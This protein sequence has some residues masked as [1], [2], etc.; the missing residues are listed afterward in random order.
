MTTPIKGDRLIFPIL[1]AYQVCL[2]YQLEQAGRPVCH[3]PIYWQG[4]HP[5]ADQC[6]CACPNGGQGQAWVRMVS[7]NAA[8]GSTR[9]AKCTNGLY[10]LTVE[11]GVYRCSPV[12]QGREPTVPAE[13]ETRHAAGMY[14]DAQALRHAM[15][16]CTWLTK[17]GVE[18]VLVH[19]SAIG[20]SGACVG[21]ELQ[22]RMQVIDCDCPEQQPS[23]SA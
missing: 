5:P 3:F 1:S 4:G 17:R 12:P 23:G 6:D 21:V 7:L 8:P 20:P 10:D 13:Q 22:M 19:E 11:L 9:T 16:C 15:R 2:E 14:R 18:P